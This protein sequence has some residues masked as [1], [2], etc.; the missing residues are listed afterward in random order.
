MRRI[1]AFA[2]LLLLAATPAGAKI[3][4]LTVMHTNDIHG[5]IGPSDATYMNREFP[6]RIGGAASM[7]TVLQRVRQ[8]AEARGQAFLLMDSGDTFQGTPIGTLTK[9]RAVIDFMNRA[10]YDVLALGNHDFDEGKENCQDLVKRANFPVLAANLLSEETGRTAEWVE[11]WIVRDFGDFKVGIVG[12]ITPETE[13]MSF[14]ANVAGLDFAPMAPIVEEAV[15]E[16]RAQDVDVI[17]AVGHVGIPYDP[18]EYMRRVEADGW[19]DD[20]EPRSN[21]MDVAH[22]VPGLDAF[23][24]G[25]IHK[26][27]D[28]AWTVPDTHTLLF[29]TYG[30]GSGAGIVTLTIDTDTNQI[31]GHEFWSARGYLVTFFEDEFWP[32]QGERDL[33]AEETAKAEEGMD[34]VIARVADNFTRG[35]PD[36]PLGNAVCEAMLEETGADFAFT[37]LGGLRADLLAG[38]VT[39]RDVFQVLPFG[40][41]MVVM[42][43]SG[44]LVREIVETR[45]A[46]GRHGLHVAGGRVVWNGTRPDF[47]RI[48]SF[49]IGGEP[50]DPAADYRIVTSDFLSQGNSNLTM[51]PLVPQAQTTYTGKTMREALENWLARHDPA[52]PSTDGRWVQDDASEPTPELRAAAARAAAQTAP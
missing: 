32:D 37:N 3:V 20:N 6:P 30:R 10:H 2:L 49:T 52:S 33:V 24:C 45:I 1:A 38:P 5:G 50:W 44:Q 7:I 31:L 47:D 36:T 43:V 13:N 27:F 21:A 23:F 42:D 9:G 14:P 51:L 19:P 25:H 39:R 22:A 28:Q 29:Q 40:N 17:L 12:V 11:P 46:Q 41:K 8:E 35:D 4:R 26:G 18:E 16:L 48:T 34:T 15:A